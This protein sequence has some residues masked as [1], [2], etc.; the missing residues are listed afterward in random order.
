[1]RLNEKIDKAVL[2]S[3][4]PFEQWKTIQTDPRAK[5]EYE[6]KEAE[7]TR[8]ATI[9]RLT[10]KYS[11]MSEEEMDKIWS[12][13]ADTEMDQ[14]IR[15][16][17]MKH[18]RVPGAIL[19]KWAHDLTPGYRGRHR[20]KEIIRMAGGAK[21]SK[22]EYG[23]KA[24]AHLAKHP[25]EPIRALGQSAKSQ[26][27]QKRQNDEE[28]HGAYKD[29]G[30]TEGLLMERIS[31]GI[32]DRIPNFEEWKAQRSDSII[33]KIKK[34]F[35]EATISEEAS[36]KDIMWAEQMTRPKTTGMESPYVPAIEE[37]PPED[38]HR[39]AHRLS[40]IISGVPFVAQESETKNPDTRRWSMILY[41]YL[42]GESGYEEYDLDD[43]ARRFG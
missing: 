26:R 8:K 30:M 20:A 10:K 22:G 35:P 29:S 36:T 5:R 18:A 23:N 19:A 3:I 14:P 1:M 12:G 15:H 24:I 33:E 17:M 6:R 2:D 42:N 38:R 9:A 13:A 43:Y 4:L 34:R 40:M 31:K 27:R 32:L 25:D 41:H 11:E 21:M 37:G 28:T 39:S 16:E 7:K